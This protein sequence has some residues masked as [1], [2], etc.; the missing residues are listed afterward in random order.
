MDKMT[1]SVMQRRRRNN[2]AQLVPAPSSQYTADKTRHSQQTLL[3]VYVP[4]SHLNTWNRD[5]ER[6]LEGHWEV[7]PPHANGV[8]HKGHRGHA[9]RGVGQRDWVPPLLTGNEGLL[10]VTAGCDLHVR[11]R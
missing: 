6:S 3:L 9:S 10:H 11:M 4:P 5:V 1:V 2:E 8:V 7:L